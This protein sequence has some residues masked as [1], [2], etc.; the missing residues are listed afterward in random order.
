MRS[1]I[2]WGI[3]MAAAVISPFTY[4]ASAAAAASAPDSAFTDDFIEKL[5]GDW[6]ISRNHEGE[7]TLHSLHAEWV[8]G[9]Q[10]LRLTMRHMADRP[11][12]EAIVMIG[13]DPAEKRYIAV[14]CDSFGGRFAAMG[15]GKR[16]GNAIEFTFQYPDGPF[17]NTFTWDPE[18]RGW[19]FRGE[20]T[21]K[22]G[23]RVLF[24]EDTV[25]R[26]RLGGR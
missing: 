9:H 25:R 2:L 24:A 21:G 4:A 17:T 16:S 26:P 7:V 15:T 1:K 12:Y 14:W 11:E 5:A 10:F 8:L 13:F 6:R 18:A 22:D 20:A 19:T 23:K 3:L